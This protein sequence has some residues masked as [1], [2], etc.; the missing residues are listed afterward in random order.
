MAQVPSYGSEDPV[1]KTG[2]LTLYSLEERFTFFNFYG[3][4]FRDL[5]DVCGYTKAGKYLFRSFRQKWLQ[6]FRNY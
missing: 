3:E 5:L 4:V 6:K 1:N 2:L